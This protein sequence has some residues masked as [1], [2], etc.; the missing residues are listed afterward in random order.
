MTEAKAC[1]ARKGHS[2]C[3]SWSWLKAF[4]SKLTRY[5]HA[6]NLCTGNFAKLVL[7]GILMLPSFH[8]I[9]F[10]NKKPESFMI[11]ISGLCV[12]KFEDMGIYRGRAS[13]KGCQPLSE[14]WI[15]PGITMGRHVI[16]N[17]Y[18]RVWTP[19]P[20]VSP[21]N[22]QE[23]PNLELDSYVLPVSSLSF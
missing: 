22:F 7:Y 15:S 6:A 10:L 16:E 20:R 19:S 1:Y 13:C 17:G 23:F 14:A 2:C 4:I 5:S 21:L 12:L 18:F 11:F 8:S 3:T 9:H